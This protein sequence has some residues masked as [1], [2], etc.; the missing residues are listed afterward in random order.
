MLQ[1][2][3]PLLLLAFVAMVFLAVFSG[4]A[5]PSDQPAVVTITRAEEWAEDYPN[6]YATYLKNE[7]MVRTT[8]GGSEPID[9]LEKYPELLT[10]Y[11][12]MGFSVEY[13]RARGH[14]YALED[15]IHTARSKPGASC[16]AC[17]TPDYVALET[18]HGTDLYAMDF[19]EM[20]V[21]AHSGVS[22]YDCHRNEPGV[23][24]IT[25][26]HLEEGLSYLEDEHDMKNL[27]CAQCHIEYYLAPDTKKVT[28]PWK[29]GTGVA[30]IEETFIEWNHVDW[31]HPQTGGELY[32]VQH[33][34]FETYLGSLHNRMNV[35]CVDCH[36]PEMTNEAG[37]NFHSHHW[38]S[39]LKYVEASCLGCHRETGP[40]LIARVEGLQGTA[41]E[42]TVAVSRRLVDLIN[43]IAT[44]KDTLDESTLN[45]VYELHRSAQ[46]R[47]DFVF[48]EN[49][50]GFHNYSKTMEYLDEADAMTDEAFR[51]LQ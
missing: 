13:L 14:V 30:G 20:A 4:C 16:M 47:W 17:K 38:T 27:I 1:R 12:G 29:H 41:E 31:V 39:P 7:E 19:N 8:F 51:L 33:P 34:E 18:E 46:L 9:Y 35:T 49:S 48:V 42:K 25:R 24:Q 26:G 50:E 37:G 23:L 36:M 15:V 10:L 40:E 44:Q 3:T 21:Q 28:V 22:C 45:Q 6:Q 2:M 43:T 5:S 32:K 11:D